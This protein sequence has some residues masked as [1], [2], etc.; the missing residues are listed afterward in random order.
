MVSAVSQAKV[1]PSAANA[2]IDC[3]TS[4]FKP[5]PGKSIDDLQ[6][7][8]SIYYKKIMEATQG[9]N[10]MNNVCVRFIDYQGRAWCQQP[11]N[12]KITERLAQG[13]ALCAA[14]I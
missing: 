3:N 14:D 6:N 2:L 10:W 1:Y 8:A 13:L 4:R 7:A 12:K 11:N 5:I 9:N